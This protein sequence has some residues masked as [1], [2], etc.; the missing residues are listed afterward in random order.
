MDNQNIMFEDHTYYENHGMLRGSYELY[1]VDLINATEIFTLDSSNSTHTD[2]SNHA[3]SKF[4]KELSAGSIAA[5]LG[6][7]SGWASNSEN[8]ISYGMRATA[9]VETTVFIFYTSLTHLILDTE[10][11]FLVLITPAVFL[12]TEHAAKTITSNNVEPQV[13]RFTILMSAI[14]SQS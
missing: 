10:S 7:I 6:V 1:D 9:A 3:Y 5:A 12:I 2:T 14:T 4:I 13:S 8:N 11:I